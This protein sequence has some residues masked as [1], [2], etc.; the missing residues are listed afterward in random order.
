MKYFLLFILFSCL[1]SCRNNNSTIVRKEVSTL[2]KKI[3]K[4]KIVYGPNI[5]IG[6]ERPEQWDEFIQ[7]K[8]IATENELIKLTE[9]NNPVIKC[10]AF[11]ALVMNESSKA[12]DILM[13]NLTDNSRVETFYGC[14]NTFECVADDFFKNYKIS[15]FTS[16]KEESSEGA[17]LSPEEVKRI[18]YEIV[19]NP[20]VKILAKNYIL[21]FLKPRDEY[22]SRIRQ[23]VINEKISDAIIT[24]ARFQK[25][26][27]K[28]LIIKCLE[29]HEY[30]LRYC[31]V[32]AIDEYP[33]I[34][35][36]K[37]LLKIV[38]QENLINRSA[39]EYSRNLIKALLKYK[40]QEVLDF[41][42]FILQ[43][44]NPIWYQ[45]L[46]TC[47]YIEIK[48]CND[49]YFLPILEKIKLDEEH[50]KNVKD[51]ISNDKSTPND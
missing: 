34:D 8:S 50:L 51:F 9:S 47:L 45:D 7:L 1:W 40:R 15:L 49:E 26:Q 21:R 37:P 6:G 20:H 2:A 14:T 35:F 3:A 48:I 17:N 19:F 16:D 4:N 13:K 10:Y 28:E 11:K 24:L 12:F 41:V 42:N 43:S 30:Q 25:P 44:N 29:S 32:L 33:D 36:F 5:N 22:Y 46:V 39:N 31:A 38:Y 27:D 23:F 18:E